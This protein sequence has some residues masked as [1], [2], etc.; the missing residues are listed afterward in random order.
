MQENLPAGLAAARRLNT[1]Y[2]E[3]VRELKRK[4]RLEEQTSWDAYGQ[5]VAS[6]VDAWFYR[7]AAEFRMPRQGPGFSHFTGLWILLCRPLPCFVMG[8]GQRSWH[9]KGAA[10]YMPSFSQVD[11]F[12]SPAVRDLARKVEPLLVERGLTR[13][14]KQEVATTLP[15]DI[16]IES[17]LIDGQPRIFDALFYWYD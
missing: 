15:A 9:A 1:D 10:G 13:L 7:D 8:E 2:P 12:D 11:R 4:Y 6:F 17:N 14:K 3:I 16:E 5:G